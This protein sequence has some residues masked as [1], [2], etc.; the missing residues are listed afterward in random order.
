MMWE[1]FSSKYTMVFLAVGCVECKRAVMWLCVYLCFKKKKKK[2]GYRDWNDAWQSLT[3]VLF[4]HSLNPILLLRAGIILVLHK[5]K[6]K[7]I[8]WASQGHFGNRYYTECSVLRIWSS[9][10][11]LDIWKFALNY[12]TFLLSALLQSVPGFR[13]IDS[14]SYKWWPAQRQ[15]RSWVLWEV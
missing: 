13:F 15:L 2:K 12:S 8:K 7:K 9:A 3:R 1:V 6:L 14:L 4:N 11:E 5:W 10:R